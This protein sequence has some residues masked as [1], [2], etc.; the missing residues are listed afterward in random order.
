MSA[1]THTETTSCARC[2]FFD[3]KQSADAGLCRFNP[4]NGGNGSTAWPEVS[5]RD[6]C[7]HFQ[8]DG[9]G[10]EARAA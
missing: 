7:G 2:N 1:G 3:E 4:P 5:S 10:V 6:W 8:F 9:R